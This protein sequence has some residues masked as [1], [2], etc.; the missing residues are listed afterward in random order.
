MGGPATTP[1]V[2]TGGKVVGQV[3]LNGHDTTTAASGPE[4]P[5][6]VVV[7]ADHQDS[8][9]AVEMHKLL[10]QPRYFDADF[11]D[12]ALRCFRCGGVGHLSRDCQNEVRQRPC[13][14]CAQFGHLRNEC[15]QA[16]CFKCKRPGHLSRECPGIPSGAEDRPCLRCA[17]RACDCSGLSDYIRAAGGCTNK[18]LRA[19]LALIRCYVCCSYGHLTCKQTPT[20]V[21]V[22]SCYNCGDSKHTGPECGREVPSSVRGEQAEIAREQ[23]R[24]YTRQQWAHSNDYMGYGVQHDFREPDGHR[25]RIVEYEPARRPTSGREES[26]LRGH[27]HSSSSGRRYGHGSIA[28]EP[29]SRKQPRSHSDSHERHGKH[30]RFF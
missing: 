16:L 8:E 28:S 17:S 19:D 7:L 23:A 14:L 15:P 29:H 10:R 27:E 20:S 5:V 24:A 13:I 21:P 25:Q 30:T 12:T 1:L 2:G 9:A 11:D 4:T 18:Y 6:G 22:K 3:G 26:G